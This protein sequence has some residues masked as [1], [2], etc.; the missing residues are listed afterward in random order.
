MGNQFNIYRHLEE[1]GNLKAR[2]AALEARCKALE[3]G[4]TTLQAAR[5]QAVGGWKALCAVGL[6]AGSIGAILAR[7][8]F[9]GGV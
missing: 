9:P 5:N 1:H 8:F 7:V 6:V 2:V 3:D 4:A